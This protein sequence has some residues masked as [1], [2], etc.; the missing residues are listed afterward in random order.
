MGYPTVKEWYEAN[1]NYLQLSD[2]YYHDETLYAIGYKNK[3]S[4]IC[5]FKS[6]NGKPFEPVLEFEDFLIY[7]SEN[8]ED[9]KEFKIEDSGNIENFFAL[10]GYRRSR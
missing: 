1:T 2:F 3:F 5:I 10:N 6:E 8:F 4:Y 9:F 7:S